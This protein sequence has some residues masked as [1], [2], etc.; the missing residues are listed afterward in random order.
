MTGQERT[1]DTR[2]VEDIVLYHGPLAELN[3]R[4][5]S[6][7]YAFADEDAI[8]LIDDEPAKGCKGIVEVMTIT[9]ELLA[10]KGYSGLVNRRTSLTASGFSPSAGIEYYFMVE[11]TPIVRVREGE[12]Q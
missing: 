12:T 6:R 4:D 8:V 1:E 2:R 5:P 9:K 10:E 3:D 7:Q 11:G